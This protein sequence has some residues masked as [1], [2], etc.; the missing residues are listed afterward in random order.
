MSYSANKRNK[1]V[2][3]KDYNIQKGNYQKKEY[4]IHNTYSPIN[5]NNNL[6]L[7]LNYE[8][9]STK[10]ENSE[11]PFFKEKEFT[12]NSYPIKPLDKDKINNFFIQRKHKLFKSPTIINKKNI[13]F[14]RQK[15]KK[16]LE[17][18]LFDENLIFK[19]I[20]KAYLQDESSDD[21][22]ESSEEKINNGT[23]YLAQEFEES[24]KEF[25]KDLKNNQNKQILSRRMRFKHDDNK[26]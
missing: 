14:Q 19:D 8:T 24:V 16:I 21:G 9:T 5:N 12:Y 25:Q 2:S 3:N 20:N 26:V 13:T 22:D 6:K 11:F 4:F 15:D 10:A 1:S 23:L 18:P 7:I 17:F